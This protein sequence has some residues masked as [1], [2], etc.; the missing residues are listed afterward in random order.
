LFI[1][2]PAEVIEPLAGRHDERMKDGIFLKGDHLGE[3]DAKQKLDIENL[4]Y[5]ILELS[6]CVLASPSITSSGIPTW[7][8]SFR[9]P[10][11]SN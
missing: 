11:V 5:R 3:A 6:K 1:V 2:S 9:R 10:S 4:L 7:R 8:E